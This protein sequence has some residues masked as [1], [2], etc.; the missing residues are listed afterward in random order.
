MFGFVIAHDKELTQEEKQRYGAVYCGICRGIRSRAGQTARLSL[1]YDMA[2]LAL[3]L[4]SLYEPEESGGGNACALHPIKKRPWADSLYIQYAA[5]FELLSCA[6]DKIKMEKVIRMNQNMLDKETAKA[7]LS[8]L[9]IKVNLNKIMVKTEKGVRFNMCKAWDDYKESGRREGRR[10]E[11]KEG[12]SSLVNILASILL[13]LD[14]IYNK[15]I[16]DKKYQNVTREQ[17]EQYYYAK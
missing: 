12:L 4:G 5:V 15:I 1:S 13:N 9:G 14:T 8:M 2:F 11:Q 10:E 17:V 6:K 3:L 16:S 7:I